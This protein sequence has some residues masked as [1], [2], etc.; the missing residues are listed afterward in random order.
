MRNNFYTKSLQKEEDFFIIILFVNKSFIRDG[1]WY[2]QNNQI[3]WLNHISTEVR[4][5]SHKCHHMSVY[6]EGFQSL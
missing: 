2:C 4:G 5:C 3:L 6:L 1:M